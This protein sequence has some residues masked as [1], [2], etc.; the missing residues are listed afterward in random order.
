MVAGWSQLQSE[1][2]EFLFG[3]FIRA[4]EQTVRSD[5]TERD[6]MGSCKPKTILTLVLQKRL[7]ALSDVPCTEEEVKNNVTAD[8]A[9]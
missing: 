2:K 6:G 8:G 4:G 1:N 3:S 7:P 5:R 9:L